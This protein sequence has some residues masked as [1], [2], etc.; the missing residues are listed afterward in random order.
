MYVIVASLHVQEEEDEDEDDDEDDDWVL[1]HP[2]EYFG[3][4]VT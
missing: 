2:A 4:F 3:S 1:R